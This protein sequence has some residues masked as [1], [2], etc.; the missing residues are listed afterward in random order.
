MVSLDR[1]CAAEV[2][3]P[4]GIGLVVLGELCRQAFKAGNLT[5][6]CQQRLSHTYK[7][8]RGTMGAASNANT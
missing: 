5:K 1:G 7:I 3:G 2:R 6:G 4:C 8:V